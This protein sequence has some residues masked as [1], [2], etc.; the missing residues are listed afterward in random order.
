MTEDLSLWVFLLQSSQQ[1]Q[2]SLLLCFCPCVG[3]LPLFVQAT[4]VADTE[5]MFVIAFG[6]GTDELFMAR[7]VRPTVASDVVV[8]TRETEAVSMTA[9]ESYYRERAVTARGTTMND[10]EIDC[11]HDRQ[12]LETSLAALYK[13]RTDDGGEY[14]DNKLDDG[15]PSFQVFE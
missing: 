10:N 6:V 1:L 7:L 4:L 14:G 5:R 13:K 9:D 15:F 11:S 3:R 12:Q 8:I 2:Q